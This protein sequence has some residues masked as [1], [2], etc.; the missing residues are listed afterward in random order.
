[1]EIKKKESENEKRMEVLRMGDA[2]IYSKNGIIYITNT[3][4]LQKS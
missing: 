2:N 4:R 1:M 3:T